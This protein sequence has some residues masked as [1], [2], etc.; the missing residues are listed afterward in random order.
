MECINGGRLSDCFERYKI[1]YNTPFFPEQIVKYIMT[2]L[3]S[4]LKYIHSNGIMH[5]DIR[6]ENIMIQYSSEKDRKDLNLLKAKIKIIDFGLAVK[7]FGKTI[8]DNPQ[9]MPPL[10]LKK[11]LESGASK[12]SKTTTYDQKIDNS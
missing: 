6:L 7:G 5:R 9:N 8:L 2:Q 10:M 1:Q 4:A 12:I 11:F 3:I